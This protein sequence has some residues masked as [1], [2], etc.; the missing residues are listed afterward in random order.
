MEEELRRRHAGRARRRGRRAVV[1]LVIA[2]LLMLPLLFLPR[3]G[4]LAG[5]SS[6]STWSLGS[7]GLPARAGEVRG[8]L[9][10]GR[11]EAAGLGRGPGR[12]HVIDTSALIDGRVADLVAHRV[13]LRHDAAARRRAAGAP[14]DRRT[15]PTPA[16]ETR[17]RRG[18][19][20]LV[21]LQKSPTVQI[22]L[23]EEA[24]RAWTWTRRL[25]AWRESAAA[26]SS[27]WT[28]TWRKVAEALARPGGADQRARLEVPDAVRGRAT[29]SRSAWS[30][31][32]ASTARA[33]ATWTTARWWSSRRPIRPD[34]H[35]V[36][37]RVTQRD[38]DDHRP[39]GLR[40]LATPSLRRRAPPEPRLPCC[41]VSGTAG[42]W[43]SCWPPASGRRLGADEPE[44]VPGDRRAADAR[45]SRSRPR[46]PRRR[47]TPWSWPPP[48]VRGRRRRCLVGLEAAR[49]GRHGRADAPSVRRAA[50]AAPVAR[51]STSWRCHDA[52]RPFASP[53]SVHR[54]RRG[55]RRRGGRRR[56]G[57]ADRRHRQACRRRSGRR[58]PSRAT[59]SPS[60]RR[61]RPSASTRSA[62]RT[63]AAD[64]GSAGVHRRRRRCS[65]GP[66]IGGHGAGRARER[67][68]HHRCSTSRGPRPGVEG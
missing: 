53:G 30:R 21:E 37:V 49:R 13:R 43:R 57:R 67:Q 38:P 26:R 55:R 59:S 9:R 47:S 10:A 64:G 3:V 20:V 35:Q 36:D 18:L 44:G 5:R 7:L 39:D 63:R 23:V 46:P 48:R 33:W 11:D 8:H 2:A 60:P 56:P 41:S 51:T 68:D 62:R 52:A 50:L 31:R 40:A 34:R 12:L 28:T 17:G 15:P 16:G 24:R 6:S 19:D 4:R 25:C 58:A 54:R 65:S 29:S 1:G 45:R 66:G 14:V 32:A 42:R 22:Q 27:R 61:R